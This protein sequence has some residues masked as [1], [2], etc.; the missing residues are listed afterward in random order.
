MQQSADPGEILIGSTTH[1]LVRDAVRV[2]PIAP[3]MLKGRSQPVDALRLLHVTSGVPGLIRHLGSPM[4]GRTQELAALQ[5]T[6]DRVLQE[7]ACHL[8]TMFGSAGVGK[9]RLIAAFVDALGDRATVLRGRCLPYGE[10]ITF[11]PLAEALIDV[12]GLSEAD[13]PQAARAKLAALVGSEGHAERVAACVGQAIGIPGS[14]TAAEETLWAIRVLLE[15]LAVERPLV[16]VIDDLQWAEPKFLELVEHVAD[17]AQDAPILLA[18]MARPELLDDHPAWAGGLLNATSIL[19]EPLG[20]EECGTLVANLFASDGVDEGVRTRIVDAAEGNPL[21]VEE[22]TAL[23]VEQGRLV[24]K[25]GRWVA[26]GDLSDVP[27]P[28]TI[29]ALLAA[30]IDKLPSDE[31]R[32]IDIASVMGQVF[33][34]GAV[35]DLANDVPTVEVA[36][37]ALVRKQFVRPERSDLPATEALVFRHLL[38]CDAAYDAIPKRTRAELHERFAD[39][40]DEAADAVGEP[41]EILGYHLE[42]AYRYRAELGQ[43]GERE[44]AIAVRACHHLRRAARSATARIDMPAAS[45]LCGRA[46]SLLDEE[47]DDYP[48]ILWELGTILNRLGENDEA[49]TVLAKVV[50]LASSKGDERLEA[51]AQ[52]DLWFAWF[53]STPKGPIEQMPDAVGSL[54]PGLEDRGDDLGLTK[55]W[56]LI[57]EG[58][59]RAC[60]FAA[61]HAAA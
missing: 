26:T 39:W 31:R 27:V 4:V 56:Q 51:R 49:V 37:A 3:L 34:S 55:A 19:L 12:A 58:R 24:L 14:E 60:Q 6:F 59:M 52:L 7:H 47:D 33:S 15:R 28:P 57:A 9:S 16:F 36:L 30:R 45:N 48:Q 44:R 11:Y 61:M 23:L 35:R 20:R 54:I 53:T 41:D 2:E 42:R 46:A 25:E 17:I 38:I 43:T 1:R 5:Q 21:Y 10:G 8:F 32:L 50:R 29:S 18:C 22:I 40:L 13:T